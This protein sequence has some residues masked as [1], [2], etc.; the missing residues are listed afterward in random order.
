[1]GNISDRIRAFRKLK[2]LTQSDL[3]KLIGVSVAL[4]GSVERG[5]R[6]PDLHLLEKISNVLNIDIDDL[7]GTNTFIERAE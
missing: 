5:T 7:T 2:G 1:M 6:V 3:A 4:L